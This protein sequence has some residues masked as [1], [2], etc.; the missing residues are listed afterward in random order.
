MITKTQLFAASA[1]SLLICFSAPASAAKNVCGHSCPNSFTTALTRSGAHSGAHS[2]T[3]DGSL[4]E[5]AL[6]DGAHGT[7]LD[8]SHEASAVPEPKTWATMLLGFGIL[9]FSIRRK[10]RSSGKLAQ[11]A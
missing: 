3:A 6:N 2:I 10:R 11:T 9:G 7:V 5:S 4:V 8:L 1:A